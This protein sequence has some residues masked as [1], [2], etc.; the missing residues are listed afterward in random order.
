MPRGKPGNGKR[1]SCR[2]SVDVAWRRW[3][4]KRQRR[5]LTKAEFIK[6]FSALLLT[7]DSFRSIGRQHGRSCHLV[8]EINQAGRIRSVET[9]KV[10]ANSSVIRQAGICKSQHNSPLEVADHELFELARKLLRGQVVCI[11]N[12][13]GLRIANGRRLSLRGIAKL[14]GVSHNVICRINNLHHDRPPARVT[15]WAKQSRQPVPEQIS[16]KLLKH[17]CWQRDSKGRFLHT[18]SELEELSGM[19]SHQFR[20]WR[21]NQSQTNGKQ[22]LSQW[23]HRHSL[24]RQDHRLYTQ[25]IRTRQERSLAAIR[26][27]DYKDLFLAAIRQTVSALGQVDFVIAWARVLQVHKLTGKQQKR[28]LRLVRKWTIS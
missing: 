5:C 15:L 10:I 11:P 19:S 6:I 2:V 27:H 13:S 21:H 1:K 18:I 9:I 24:I 7:Q 3:C 17:L 12:G 14:I 28:F 26:G 23:S 22:P 4:Q 8:S 20:K 16:T 25:P